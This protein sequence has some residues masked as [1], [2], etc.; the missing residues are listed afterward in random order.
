MKKN[1]NKLEKIVISLL[2]II[3]IAVGL[4]FNSETENKTEN[5]INNIENSYEISNIP[6]Y[7][8]EIHVEI[9]NNIP[10]F[11]VEDMNLEGD[12]Y[13]DLKSGRVRN[14]N[15]KNKLEKSKRR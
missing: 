2:F 5:T 10:E 6:E 9:N 8:G 1:T 12:Y 4:Y 13:S 15:D 7:S 11:T 3:I 14:S